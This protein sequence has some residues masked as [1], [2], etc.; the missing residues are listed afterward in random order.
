MDWDALY[1]VYS[2]RM[3]TYFYKVLGA[4][5]DLEDL[6]S[7]VFCRAMRFRGEVRKVDSWLFRIAHNVA[8]DYL[9]AGGECSDYGLDMVLYEIDVDGDPELRF[10][11]LEL[12]LDLMGKMR[13][14]S[15]RQGIALYMVY[16]LG[17]PLAEAAEWMGVTL[18]TFKAVQHR[19]IVNMRILCGVID[20]IVH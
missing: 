1:R 20:E 10:L 4:S 14:L 16:G 19:G 13:Q 3:L 17:M 11:D 8:V 2:R 6:V 7:E 18:G 9:R 15:R 12:A 5:D